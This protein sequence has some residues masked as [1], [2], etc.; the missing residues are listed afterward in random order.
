M[1][2]TRGDRKNRDIF[3]FFLFFSERLASSITGLKE[4]LL[5]ATSVG[6]DIFKGVVN[7]ELRSFF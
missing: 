1:R 5:S 3:I 2:W 6:H 4:Y 7:Y